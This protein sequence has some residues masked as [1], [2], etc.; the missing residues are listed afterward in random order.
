MESGESEAPHVAA[1]P[2]VAPLQRNEIPGV[3]LS[4]PTRTPPTRSPDAMQWN[5]GVGGTTR[6]RHCQRLID[7]TLS[8]PHNCLTFNFTGAS[9]VS[10]GGFSNRSNKPGRA[11]E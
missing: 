7:H 3:G 11:S 2:S 1:T 6:R 10:V 9:W 4:T 5:P 8:K